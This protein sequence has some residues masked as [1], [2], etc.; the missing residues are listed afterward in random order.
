MHKRGA[1]DEEESRGSLSD[2]VVEWLDWTGLIFFGDGRTGNTKYQTIAGVT[3]AH[4]ITDAI[5]ISIVVS[6]SESEWECDT[7]A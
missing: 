3:N 4:S 5:S 2:F 1:I 6:E 7:G